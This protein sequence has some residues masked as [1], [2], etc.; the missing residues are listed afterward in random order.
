[1][2]REVVYGKFRK[3]W[4]RPSAQSPSQNLTAHNDPIRVYCVDS[5]SYPHPIGGQ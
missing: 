3:L 1:M 2:C 5:E 4:R